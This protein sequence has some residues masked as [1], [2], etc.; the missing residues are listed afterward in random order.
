MKH[1]LDEDKNINKI[2]VK[3]ILGRKFYQENNLNIT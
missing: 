2:N 1:L 3:L